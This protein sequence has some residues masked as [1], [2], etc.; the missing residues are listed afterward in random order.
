MRPSSTG[1]SEG[2]FGELSGTGRRRR[3]HVSPGHG[4]RWRN[5]LHSMYSLKASSGASK[6]GAI[7]N[8]ARQGI[9]WAVHVSR[10][11]ARIEHA[12][13]SRGRS[14]TAEQP[15]KGPGPHWVSSLRRL[16]TVPS[17]H[18]SPRRGEGDDRSLMPS[19]WKPFRLFPPLVRRRAKLLLSRGW[20]HNSPGHSPSQHLVGP[21]IGR[22]MLLL[23]QPWDGVGVMPVERVIPSTRR[24]TL[25]AQR[26]CR[27][28]HLRGFVRIIRSTILKF[29]LY[30]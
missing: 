30:N 25:S 9:D 5:G 29:I 1:F 22:A 13:P 20:S 24:N 3:E 23:S 15:G 26:F 28:S 16:H 12:V 4:G 27:K 17:P 6:S 18:P 2:R 7:Q 21:A 11:R 8:S 14:K 10:C 19:F